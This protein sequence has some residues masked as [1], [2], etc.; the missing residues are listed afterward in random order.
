MTLSAISMAY[1]RFIMPYGLQKFKRYAVNVWNV[2]L[3]GKTD[4]QI[5]KEGLDQMEAYMKE[6]GLVMSIK[7]LGVTKD[8]LDGIANGSF[9]MEGGYKVL[10]HDEIVLVL[11][12]SMI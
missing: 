8:M 1:Y 10:I 7:D 9:I 12:N 5:A 2:N 11:N 3:E 6:M 4:E